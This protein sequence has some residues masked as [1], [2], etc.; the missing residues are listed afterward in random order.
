MVSMVLCGDESTDEL[1][2]VDQGVGSHAE[3]IWDGMFCDASPTYR[4]VVVQ[5]AYTF[6]FE[7]SCI[8]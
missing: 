2:M 1:H 6:L 3:G 5:Q 7:C 4:M 8:P